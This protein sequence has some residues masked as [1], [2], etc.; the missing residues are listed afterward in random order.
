MK[1]YW[2]KPE[3]TKEAIVDGWFQTGDTGYFDKDGFLYIHDRVKDMIV[4]GGENIYPAEIENALFAHTDIADVAVVG[5]PD[6][7]WGE[8]VLAFV[9][10]ASNVELS[11]TAVIDFAKTKIASFKVPR[12]IVFIEVL[13][14]NPSGKILRRELRDPFWE[15]RTR[16][17]N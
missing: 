17:V 14:R 4:S 6:D 3:A 9:V 1:G 5:I 8:S 7:N 2:N 13:P 12:K 10:R 16:G 15:G 11:E